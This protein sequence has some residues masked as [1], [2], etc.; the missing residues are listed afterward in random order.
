MSKQWREIHSDKEFIISI[1]DKRDYKTTK[2][3]NGHEMMFILLH[4]DAYN[5]RYSMAKDGRKQAAIV[6]DSKFF[7]PLENAHFYESEMGC[8]KVVKFNELEGYEA[9]YLPELFL[10]NMKNLLVF[11]YEMV[12]LENES[13]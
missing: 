6:A 9:I 4:H 11:V 1:S 2:I 13:E 12:P 5:I 8:E 7:H 3:V 10:L